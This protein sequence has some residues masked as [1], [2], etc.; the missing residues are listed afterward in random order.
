MFPPDKLDADLVEP[1]WLPKRACEAKAKAFMRRQYQGVGYVPHGFLGELQVAWTR[2]EPNVSHA[3]RRPEDAL[4][5]SLG[6]HLRASYGNK[7]HE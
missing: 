1:P 4:S 3:A 5:S 2:A 6:S 7:G